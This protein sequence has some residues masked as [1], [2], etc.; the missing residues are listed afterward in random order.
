[1]RLNSYESGYSIPASPVSEFL[2]IR[3]RVTP[4]L[5]LSDEERPPLA[6]QFP[7]VRASRLYC[8]RVKSFAL[9]MPRAVFVCDGKLRPPHCDSRMATIFRQQVQIQIIIR[10]A[11]FVAN[12]RLSRF[13]NSWR[14][15]SIPASSGECPDASIRQQ[16]MNS[17]SAD[18]NTMV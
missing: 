9:F 13:C 14:M 6:F 17:C 4:D 7:K 11:V 5:S 10:I 12:T 18:S 16:Q 2:R 8:G 3:L 15:I 1:M